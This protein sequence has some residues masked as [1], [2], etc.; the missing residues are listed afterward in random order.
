M[1]RFL[2][3]CALVVGIVLGVLRA[4]AIRWWRVPSDDPYLTASVSPSLRPGDLILLWRLTKPGFG[5]LVLC[6]EPKRPDRVVIGRL[7]GEGRDELEVT[8]GDITVNGRRQIVES[9]CVEKVFTEHDPATHIQVEQRCNA[10][11][12]NGEHFRGEIPP[13]SVRP[14]DVKTTVPDG[15]VWLVS[16]NR[17]YPYDSRDFGPVPRE[18]CTELVFFRLV[19]AGG[20]FD[21]KTRNQFIR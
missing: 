13:S 14:S 19:G 7:V 17:L 10:E 1:F 2:F 11:D 6:P 4:T 9:S 3:W 8:G 21:T 12:I 15:N 16:D 18:T 20:F 5:D